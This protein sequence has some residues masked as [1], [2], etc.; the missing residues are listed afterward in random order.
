MGGSFSCAL[1]S[2]NSRIESLS[3]PVVLSFFLRRRLLRSN[4]ALAASRRNHSGGFHLVVEAFAVGVAMV[5]LQSKL[6]VALDIGP[7]RDEHA[8]H[9]AVADGSIAPRPMMTDD[10]VIPRRADDRVPLQVADDP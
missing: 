5:S 9:H 4:A 7:L 3:L 6:E 10:V 2:L 1:R 8:I